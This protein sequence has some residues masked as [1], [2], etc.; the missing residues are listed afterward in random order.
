MSDLSRRQFLLASASSAALSGAPA[1]SFAADA[2]ATPKRGGTVVATWGGLEPQALFVPAGGGN[3]PFFT[4]TKFHE[5]LLKLGNDLKFHPVL[6]ESV[7]PAADFLSYTVK[8]RKGVKWHDGRPFTAA[9]LVFTVLQYWKPISVGV[10]LAGLNVAEAT[11][12]HT[13][14]LRFTQ[15]ISE[16]AFKSILAGTGGLVIPKHVYEKGDI[17]TNAANNAPVGTGPYKYKEWVRGSH[18]ELVRNEDYWAPGQPY[19]D[20]LIIR[21]WRDPAS[22]SAAFEA[23]ELHLA[24]F[25]PFPPPEIERLVKT[26]KFVAET[27]GYQNATWQT[28]LH[29]NTKNEVTSKVDVRRAL[30]H[31]INRKFIADT[32]YFKYA[33]PGIGPVR[34][35]NELFYNADIPTYPFDPEKAKKLLDDA[36]YP[37]KNGSRFTVKVLAPAWF[38][39]NVKTGNYIKQALTDIGVKVDLIT[40]DRATSLKL[41]FTDYDFDIGLTNNGTPL[42]LVPEVTMLY[43]TDGIIKGAAFRNN[44][45]YSNPKLD[46]VVAQLAREVNYEKR[47]ALAHEFARIANTDVPLLPLV[48]NRSITVASKKVHNHSNAANYTGESWGDLWIDS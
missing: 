32:V 21:W 38:E 26:G 44:S 36:G 43:T 37:V 45:R 31:A 7:E 47:K 13:V 34:P 28:Y 5:R 41:L 29:F 12:D 15:T 24:V 39:E 23:G 40:P 16:F 4:S 25:N 9:D 33:E 3:S 2:G 18:V 20:R 14:V 42:E 1:L 48:V 11:D 27:A 17:A 35:S 46:D 8:L 22:R 6:A 30:L 10:P 19:L